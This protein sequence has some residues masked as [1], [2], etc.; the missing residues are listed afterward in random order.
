MSHHPCWNGLFNDAATFEF[1]VLE[2]FISIPLRNSD[3]LTGSLRQTLVHFYFGL[4][5]ILWDEQMV[6]SPQEKTENRVE[7]FRNEAMRQK[8]ME[9][10]QLFSKLKGYVD[11]EQST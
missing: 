10:R 5:L 4:L 7:I 8:L 6:E 11:D 9:K 2:P 3:K 1:S